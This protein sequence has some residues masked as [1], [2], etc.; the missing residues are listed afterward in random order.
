MEDLPNIKEIKNGTVD[1]DKLAF[2]IITGRSEEDIAQE[3]SNEGVD[4]T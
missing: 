2:N 4:E 3:L 1:F